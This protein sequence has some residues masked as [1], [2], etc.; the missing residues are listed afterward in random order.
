MSKVRCGFC[1]KELKPGG[2]RYVL[3]WKL[4]AD[5][6]GI[7]DIEDGKKLEAIMNPVETASTAEIQD[8]IYMENRHVLCPQCREE[9]LDTLA[10][11]EDH[12]LEE[13]LGEANGEEEKNFH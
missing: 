12:G 4:F 5:Y 7:I 11:L 3:M 1:A 8:Q 13:D 10:S 2:L 9:I 6:D